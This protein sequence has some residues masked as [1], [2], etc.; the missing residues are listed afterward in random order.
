MADNPQVPQA[1]VIPV[2][3]VVVP[4]APQAAPPVEVPAADAGNLEVKCFICFSPFRF[5][6]YRVFHH[7]LGLRFAW[8]RFVPVFYTVYLVCVLFAMQ[9]YRL[10]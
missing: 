6:P 7:V 9:L 1:P 5:H 4:A 10:R 8:V 2:A 3:E